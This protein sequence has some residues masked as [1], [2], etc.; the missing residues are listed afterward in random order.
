MSV[1]RIPKVAL[2]ALMRSGNKYDQ[3][4]AHEQNRKPGL[5]DL[6]FLKEYSLID[7]GAVRIE[8]ALACHLLPSIEN[9]SQEQALAD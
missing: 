4:I 2:R 5:T 8:G 7:N 6:S 9:E 1:N 3:R